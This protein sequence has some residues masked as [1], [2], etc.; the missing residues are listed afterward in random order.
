[1]SSEWKLFGVAA[2]AGYVE[3]AFDSVPHAELT[4][5]AVKRNVKK[6]ITSALHRERCQ[7]QCKVN[8]P[9][10]GETSPIPYRRGGIQG[11]PSTPDEFRWVLEDII[12]PLEKE[13]QKKGWGFGGV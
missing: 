11:G 8:S 2:F 4:L 9:Y 3:F 5:A 13:W 10:F 6:V 1:M 7:I 12:E